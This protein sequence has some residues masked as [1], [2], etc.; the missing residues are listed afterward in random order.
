MNKKTALEQLWGPFK[1]QQQ[2]NKTKGQEQP[3]KKRRK[4]ASFSLH[5][6]S[7][8]QHQEGT[9]QLESAPL[10]VSHK[11]GRGDCFLQYSD[12]YAL[13][14]GITQGQGNI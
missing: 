7:I 11:S 9:I 12:S 10:P 6:A 5:H 3:Y 14:T 13:T 4:T 2:H 1:K 8:A